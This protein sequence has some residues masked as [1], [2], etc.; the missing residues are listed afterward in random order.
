LAGSQRQ[1][2]PR[3]ADH[4]L[5]LTARACSKHQTLPGHCVTPTAS[6][7]YL[8][9]PGLRGPRARPARVGHCRC[10][11]TR[12][13]CDSPATPTCSA[14]ARRRPAVDPESIAESRSGRMHEGHDAPARQFGRG[15]LARIHVGAQR[16]TL[17][18]Q[19]SDAEAARRK[20]RCTHLPG[21]RICSISQGM[22][23][24]NRRAAVIRRATK[25]AV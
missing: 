20:R 4:V 10:D 13:R 1:R 25:C 7:I 19:Q 22:F 14:A 3:H 15:S 16:S 17:P 5:W 24:C 2:T 12:M 8:T 18:E 11:T 23:V 6:S 9:S 21:C